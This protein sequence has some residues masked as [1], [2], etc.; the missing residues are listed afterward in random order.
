[1]INTL[2]KRE[3]VLKA[4]GENGAPE[5]ELVSLATMYDAIKAAVGILHGRKAELGVWT[6][7]LRSFKW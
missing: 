3:K 2:R 7:V 5:K 4:L 6:F 1:M